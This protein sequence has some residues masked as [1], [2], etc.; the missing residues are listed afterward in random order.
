MA[1]A[2]SLPLRRR[3]WPVLVNDATKHPLVQDLIAKR[4]WLD[5]ELTE[6]I[7]GTG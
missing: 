2:Y 3:R 7:E 6:L 4:R 1:A 5:Q